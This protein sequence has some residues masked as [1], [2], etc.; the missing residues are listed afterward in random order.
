MERN[1]V[2]NYPTLSKVIASCIILLFTGLTINPALPASHSRN[3][4]I[5]EYV[6]LIIND[7]GS[8]DPTDKEVDIPP[9]TPDSGITPTLC[10]NFTILGVNDSELTRFYGDDP[11][12]DWTSITVYGDLLYPINET[13]L[14]HVGS[15][16]DWNYIMTPTKQSGEIMLW[17]EWPEWGADWETIHI[18]NG[19][20]VNPSVDSFAW[21]FDFKLTVTIRDM[22][23]EALKYCNVSLLWEEENV[24]FNETQGDNTLGNGRNGEYSFWIRQGEQGELPPKN[25]TIAA[26]DE[27]S[28][29]SGYTKIIMERPN[30]PPLVFVDDD[31]NSSTSG[32]GYNHFNTIET[33]VDSVD[34]NGT[35]LVFN[36]IYPESIILNK[37]LRLLGEDKYTTRIEGT[38]IGDAINITDDNVT[39]QGFTIQ[40]YTEGNGIIIASNHNKIMDNI[41]ADNMAG[42][43][44][45]YGNPFETIDSNTGYNII[46]HNRIIRNTEGNIGLSG[47]NNSIIGNVISSSPFGIMMA[48][49]SSNTVLQNTIVDNEIGVGILASYHTIVTQNNISQNEKLGVFDFCTSYTIIRQNNFI[50]NGQ[51]AY[52]RQTI[53]LR[54]GILHTILNC[55]INRSIWDEN[56]WEKQRIL[57]YPIPGLISFYRGFVNDPP[58]RFNFFQI[59]RHPAKTPYDI[60]GAGE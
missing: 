59:D 36:G 3:T 29:L 31:Y 15:Q 47:F 52:F 23:M 34:T 39:I 5:D 4:P 40:N 53:A 46:T 22:D 54:F 50:G 49:S 58:Y 13:T 55:P 26:Y 41:I 7:D 27:S 57:P 48:V 30:I 20:F 56:Y 37:T 12:E 42:I 2:K 9:Y 28:R 14:Y 43:V 6:D 44:T 17:I 45:Y 32:W 51:Q 8:G 24:E 11:G 1:D 25:I 60:P 16:G 38:G 21:G 35:V 19:S 18:I 33:G 10:I